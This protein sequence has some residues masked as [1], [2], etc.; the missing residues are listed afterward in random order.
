MLG[1]NHDRIILIMKCLEL[2]FAVNCGANAS[3]IAFLP[4]HP[5]A[6][7]V[8]ATVL[9][10]KGLALLFIVVQAPPLFVYCCSSSPIVVCCYCSTVTTETSLNVRVLYLVSHAL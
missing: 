6:G 2:N 3:K 10:N 4:P 7:P 9:F 1:T 5:R 8:P